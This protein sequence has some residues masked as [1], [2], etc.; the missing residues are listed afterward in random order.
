MFEKVKKMIARLSPNGI[1]DA[2]LC[3]SLKLAKKAEAAR[4]A[5]ELIGAGGFERR[6][7]KCCMCSSV[8]SVTRKA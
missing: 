5:R 6:K 3:T 4:F 7:E 1:C 8:T 2:C